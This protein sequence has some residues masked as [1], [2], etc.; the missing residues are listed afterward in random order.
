LGLPGPL[1]V[2]VSA[3]SAAARAGLRPTR[4]DSA[5]RVSLGDILIAVDG[6]TVSS[7]NELFLVLEQ[8]KV[9][10]TVTVKFLREGKERQAKVTLEAIR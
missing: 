9:G 6:K 10:D 5:G 2:D 1:I 3:G 4:R 7:A 8:Y